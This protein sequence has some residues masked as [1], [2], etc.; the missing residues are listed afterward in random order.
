[1]SI[2]SVCS[3]IS[4]EHSASARVI[5][6]NQALASVG[7]D[8][9][10][11]QCG[12]RATSQRLSSRNLAIPGAKSAFLL[13]SYHSIP[14]KLWSKIRYSRYRLVMGNG[15]FGTFYL[16]LAVRSKLPIVFDMH[17]GL[18]EEVMFSYDMTKNPSWRFLP[19]FLI[20]G[21]EKI[22]DIVDIGTAR[23]I[24]CVSRTMMD[25]LHEVKQVPREKLIYFPNAIDLEFFKPSAGRNP[26]LREKLGLRNELVFGYVGDT[27]KWQGLEN[28]IEAAGPF[29]NR[30]IC[31]LIIGGRENRR[32]GD[33]I[34]LPRIPRSSI[35]D[36]YNLCD[37]LVLPRPK[38]PATEIAAPTKFAEYSAM[39]KP[40]LTTNVGDAARLVR[41]YDFGIVLE[42]NQPQTLARGIAEMA[43]LSGERLNRMGENARRCAE[44]EFDIRLTAEEFKRSVKELL[45]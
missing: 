20:Y 1:M 12:R 29:R 4:G 39:G 18:P 2:L 44:E 34:H 10:F 19:R 14:I 21:L 31:F 37:V 23:R 26:R 32:E 13:G 36:Y 35:T 6:V 27:Q 5:Q 45:A 28:F 11:I 25:Y 15:H 30:N 33:V 16:S 24:T 17:G 43:A 9:D 8:V 7:H 3:L 22:I 40:V 42:N 38:H 41:Q